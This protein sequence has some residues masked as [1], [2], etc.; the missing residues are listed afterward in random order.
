MKKSKAR[1]EF[2]LFLI[3]LTPIS[4]AQSWQSS[5]KKAN[6]FLSQ[7]RLETDNFRARILAKKALALDKTFTDAYWFLASCYEKAHMTDSAFLILQTAENQAKTSHDETIFKI[8]KKHYSLGEYEKSIEALERT[9]TDFSPKKRADLFERNRVAL[10]LKRNPVEFS[11][12]NL[13]AVNTPYDDYWPSLSL[14]ER[15]ISTTVL[16]ADK[17]RPQ[18]EWNEEIFWSLKNDSGQWNAA[19]SIGEPINTE[20]N[21]GSQS[22][23][24]D[25][26]YLFFVA[27][28]LADSRGGCDI[29]YSVHDGRGWSLPINAGE[30][31]NSRFWES[32]PCL[33][34]DGRE[35]FFA[36]NRPGGKGGMDIWE[37]VVQR[38]DDGTLRF[39]NPTNLSAE[40]NTDGDEFS[41]F[42]HPDGKTLYFSSNGHPGLGGQDIFFSRRDE[43]FSWSKAQNIG[44]PINTHKDE[45]G[46]VVSP[47]GQEAFFSS[48]IAPENGKDIFK[49]DLYASARPSAMDYVFGTVRERNSGQGLAAQI[50]FFDFS[51]NKKQTVFSGADGSFATFLPSE[52]NYDINILKPDFLLFSEN[53][54]TKKEQRLVL[55]LDSIKVGKSLILKNIAFETDSYFLKESSKNELGKVLEFLKNQPRLRLEIVGHTDNVGDEKYNLRLSENRAKEVEKFLISIGVEPARIAAVGRGQTE[56]IADNQTEEGR[57]KNRRTELKIKNL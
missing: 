28:D 27:C 33:S 18:L 43:N 3:F 19:R 51:Q 22:F 36:S 41:P 52:K 26:K 20:E 32:T 44:Y 46:F 21:E 29:Y 11:P 9:A 54:K 10:A 6:E 56:P 5:S 57:A 1:C 24:A 45:F 8:A 40:I 34:A 25:G 35:I 42:F 50:D 17:S 2:L 53:V 38:R 14:G 48:D 30:P 49:F 4:W 55:E 16:I 23:S 12:T 31:L 7:A 39:S 15:V 13:T 47:S 37:C